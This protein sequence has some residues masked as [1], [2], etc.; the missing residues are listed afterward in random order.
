MP[1]SPQDLRQRK[2]QS[3]KIDKDKKNEPKLHQSSHRMDIDDMQA[4][5]QSIGVHLNTKIFSREKIKK[6]IEDK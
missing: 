4:H 2:P 5:L 6:I 1:S 3:I